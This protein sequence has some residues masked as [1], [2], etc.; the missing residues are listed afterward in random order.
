MILENTQLLLAVVVILVTLTVIIGTQA[1]LALRDMRKTLQKTNKV[2]DEADE[3]LED[4]G[5]PIRNISQ[6][7]QGLQAVGKVTNFL[8]GTQKGKKITKELSSHGKHALTKVEEL[9]DEIEAD[10]DDDDYKLNVRTIRKPVVIDHDDG[11]DRIEQ[12]SPSS[13]LTA[14][15]RLFKGLPKKR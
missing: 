7:F 12:I 4:I 15:R 1:F 14:G 10:G 3:I 8:F 11:D 6:T 13:F 9:V 5:L 2:L